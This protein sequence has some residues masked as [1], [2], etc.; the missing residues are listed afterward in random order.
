M[1]SYSRKIG[2]KNEKFATKVSSRGGSNHAAPRRTTSFYVIGFLLAVL[3]LSGSIYCTKRHFSSER[4]RF[5][6]RLWD[7]LVPERNWTLVTPQLWLLL[8]ATLSLH[9]YNRKYPKTH[10]YLLEGGALLTTNISDELYKGDA[11]SLANLRHLKAIYIIQPSHTNILRLCDQLRGGYFKEYHLYFTSAPLEGQLE[12]LAK[13]D[14]L[15]LVCGVYAYHT[16]LMAICRHCFLLDAGTSD[17]YTSVHS[18]EAARVSQGLFNVF[19]IIKQIPAVVH[20]NNSTEARELGLKVQSLLNNDLLN[21]EAILKTY[22]KFGTS[23]SFGCCL[24]IYDRKFDCVT[25]LMNQWSY[26]AMIYEMLPVTRNSVRIGEE[27]FI[28]NPDFDDFYGSHLFKEFTD[29]ESALSV[30]IQDNKKTFTDAVNILQNLPQQTKA[31]NETK[32]HVALLHELSRLIQ[33]RQLLET[34]LLEQDMGTHNKGSADAFESVVEMLN[35]ATVDSFEKLRL[36]MLFCLEYRRHEDKVNMIKDNLRMNG[37]ESMVPKLDALLKYAVRPY[38]QYT[39]RLAQIVQSLLKGRLDPRHFSMIPSSYDLEFTLATRPSSVV[40]Y[41]VGGVTLCEYRDLQGLSAAT[42]VPILLAMPYRFPRV[43]LRGFS[44]QA[45][46]RWE[47][48]D[49]HRPTVSALDKYR[50]V[51]SA[52]RRKSIRRSDFLKFTGGRRPLISSHLKAN[53]LASGILVWCV[54]A[55]YMTYRVMRP[56]DYAWVD[57]ERVRIEAAKAK[58]QRIIDYEKSVAGSQTSSN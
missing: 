27:D 44:S 38:M 7:T 23:E 58:M 56:E 22:S 20:V 57:A 53:L 54:F 10:S 52:D 24:L 9:Y 34:A 33:S 2:L 35:S 21:S 19:Q 46:D 13:N 6:E 45:K 14:I 1:S 28:L 4:A 31:C 11:K 43:L 48:T 5:S 39:S 49:E 15:E 40:V 16:D 18:G 37:L 8:I 55:C 30:M 50:E 29:V 3:V 47:L 32:R 25:P 51:L 17:V 12:M 36:A 41:V 42:G 26:Q